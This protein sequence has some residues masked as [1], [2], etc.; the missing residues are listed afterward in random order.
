MSQ[1]H[2]LGAGAMGC[3]ISCQMTE[4]RCD[5]T[6]LHHHKRAGE[7]VVVDGQ[8]EA[9]LAVQALGALPPASIERL[10]ITTKAGQVIDA[11]KLARP[12]LAADA[13]IAC[14]AN[15]LG[16]EDRFAETFPNQ[17]LYRAVT[18][19]GAFRDDKGAVHIV[20]D[21]KTRMGLAGVHPK[22]PHWFD[23]SLGRLNGW[24]W[25]ANIEAAI[26]KKFSIN[27]VINPL[28]VQLKCRN[29]GLLESDQARPELRAL[30][31]E[32]QPA[33]TALGLWDEQL[34]LLATAVDVCRNTAQN[35]SSMLQDFIAG[36]PTEIDYLNGEL[37]RRATSLG[38]ELPLNNAL[39]D[40]LR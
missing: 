3:L 20:S 24:H 38:R 29:G 15:G 18:T 32:S 4:S 28:T 26:A 2:I 39:V 1:W 37:V 17:R 30:C 10:L 35:K 13:V 16:F 12:Y 40:A 11:L 34:D 8:T 27:C 5:H 22:A 14:T 36:R 19:A 7:R 23:D 25:E 9:H 33:L 6:L 21:G 31:E